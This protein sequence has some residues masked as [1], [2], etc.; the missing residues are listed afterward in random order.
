MLNDILESFFKDP[1]TQMYPEEKIAPPERYRGE[2][3]FDPKLC[4]GCTLCVKD[5][6][7]NAIRLTI[8]D[9]AAKR[10][11]MEYHRDRCVYCGQC[12]VNCKV[13]C[14]HMSHADWEHAVLSKEFI[15]HYGRDEDVNQFLA[16][17]AAATAE[18]TES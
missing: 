3:Y 15:V 7:S 2:L 1:A 14:L 13:K 9:R 8:L 6:P 11:I 16:S 17:I 4:T 10:Y 5:C 12:V 18:A